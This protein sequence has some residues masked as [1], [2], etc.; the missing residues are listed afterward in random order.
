[1]FGRLFGKRTS[2]RRGEDQVWASDAA[3]LLGVQRAALGFADEGKSVVVVALAAAAVDEWAAALAPRSPA[4]CRD[5]FGQA[6][7]RARLAQPGGVSVA[8]A[9]ALSRAPDGDVG[10]TPVE[11]LVVGR[12]A[13]REQDDEIAGFADGLGARAGVTFHLAFSDP[14][15]AKHAAGIKG[16]LERLGAR[17]EDAI[18]HPLVTRSIAKAQ[19]RA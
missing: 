10:A 13:R 15:L 14:L 6:P 5:V 9:S 7:L 1:M 12:H 19:R 17:D 3:R 2:A 8:L 16:V 4:V 18:S 11:L